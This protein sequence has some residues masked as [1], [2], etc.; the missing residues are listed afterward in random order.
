MERITMSRDLF[1]E[2]DYQGLRVVDNCGRSKKAFGIIHKCE[3][4]YDGL[5]KCQCRSLALHDLF[6]AIWGVSIDR[7][8]DSLDAIEG[9]KFH[10]IADVDN[11]YIKHLE[12]NEC[13][14]YCPNIIVEEDENDCK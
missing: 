13:L 5:W 14:V 10:D 6:I 9:W 1:N 8:K 2:L 11:F 3:K 12:N 7:G 4:A